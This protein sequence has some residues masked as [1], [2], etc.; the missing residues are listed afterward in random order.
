M[1]HLSIYTLTDHKPRFDVQDREGEYF[2]NPCTILE[3]CRWVYSS[4]DWSFFVR[5]VQREEHFFLRIL[6][7]TTWLI[8]ELLTPTGW[9]NEFD[10]LRFCNLVLQ[11]Y[12]FSDLPAINSQHIT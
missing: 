12:H 1:R 7:D 2:E 8:L 11:D 3:R 5:S 6:A 10:F 4:L 9:G